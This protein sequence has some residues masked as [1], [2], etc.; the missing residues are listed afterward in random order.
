MLRSRFLALTIFPAVAVFGQG[1]RP[2]F[3]VASA[4]VSQ[5]GR[6]GVEGRGRERIQVEPD[7]VLMAN[8]SFRSCT[9]WAYNVL[10]YQVNGPGWI[11]TERYDITGKASGPV[12]PEQLRLMMQTL[13]AERFKMELHRQTKE[14]QAYLLQIAK[15]GPKFTESGADGEP[16]MQRDQQSMSISIRR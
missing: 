4:K 13:L 1:S 7:A 11:D 3:E 15:G 16:D 6:S 14:M 8:V 12:P 2:A 10:D 9:R 5:L